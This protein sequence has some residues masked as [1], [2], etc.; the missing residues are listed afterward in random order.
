MLMA[1]LALSICLRVSSTPMNS[2]LLLGGRVIDPANRFDALA[3]LLVVDGK[4]AALGPAAVRQAPA[5]TETLQAK[6]WTVSVSAGACLTAWGPRA[7]IL[8][9]TTSK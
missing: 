8:P 5:E 9:S 2:L 7:A 4:I 1:A 6:G 3:D